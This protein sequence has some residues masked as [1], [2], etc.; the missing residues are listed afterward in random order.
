ML[1]IMMMM[2]LTMIMVLM[3][4]R[5]FSFLLFSSLY[6]STTF[7]FL[8]SIHIN[9]S[10]YPCFS[11]SLFFILYVPYDVRPSPAFPKHIENFTTPMTLLII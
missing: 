5:Y 8:S 7:S 3:L 11:H 10:D 1:M 9:D 2:I 4:A 6:F